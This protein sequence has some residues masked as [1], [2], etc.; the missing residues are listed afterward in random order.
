ML[1]HHAMLGLCGHRVPRQI[2]LSFTRCF[3]I[4]KSVH[5][6]DEELSESEQTMYAKETKSESP[7]LGSV[8][9]HG[10]VKQ[11]AGQN[12]RPAIAEE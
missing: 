7:C 4:Q 3:V 9:N 8:V 12:H 5:A 11:L 6:A 1:M 2:P 10:V